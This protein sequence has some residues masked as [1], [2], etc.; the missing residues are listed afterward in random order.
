MSDLLQLYYWPTPNGW[1]ITIMLEELGAPYRVNFIDIAKGEQFE[2]AFLKISPNNRIP[3]LV[4]PW[5]RRKSDRDLRIPYH[6]AM[7]A[8]D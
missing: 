8:A 3:A 5:G 1:K 2:P 7:R 6:P 4:D